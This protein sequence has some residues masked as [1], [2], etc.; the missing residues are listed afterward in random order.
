MLVEDTGSEMKE[1]A[2]LYA[3]TYVEKKAINT[4]YK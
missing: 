1:T 3:E 2:P 4:F